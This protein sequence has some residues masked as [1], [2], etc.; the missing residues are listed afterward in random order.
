MPDPIV[1]LSAMGIAFAVSDLVVG[2]FGWPRRTS[3]RAW[4][5]ASWVLGVASGF[6]LGCWVLG[7]RPHWPPRDDHD[8]L[9]IV[10]LPAIVL[11]ELLA[12]SKRVPR[13]LVNALRAAVII[14]TAPV[15]LFG[16]SYLSDQNGRR[17]GVVEGPGVFDSGGPGSR[18]GRRLVPAGTAQCQGPEC[19]TCRLP[20][21]NER[22][23]RDRRHALWLRLRRPERS[24]TRRGRSRGR[25]HYGGWRL[26]VRGEQS[27]GVVDHHA[28][29]A[30][31]SRPVLW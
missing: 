25:K 19:N 6:F 22:G 1:I 10:V 17:S 12:A 7:N 8:R 20:G 30:S 24:D 13:W 2:G 5:D 26:V 11:V 27:P 14:G 28:L 9:F 29:C 15:L 18:R 21:W 16:T 31:H 3:G 4:V 23:R